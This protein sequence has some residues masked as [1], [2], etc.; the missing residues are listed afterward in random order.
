MVHHWHPGEIYG[1]WEKIHHSLYQ[2]MKDLPRESLEFLALRAADPII[3]R[4]AAEVLDWL[5]NRETLP[6]WG[7]FAQA[8]GERL[9]CQP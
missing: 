3:R 7:W 8:G 9:R 5:A 1:A 4:K 2:A 6:D